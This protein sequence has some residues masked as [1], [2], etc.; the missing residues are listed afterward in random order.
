MGL[1]VD[2]SKVERK[3]RLANGEKLVK[4][5]PLNNIRSLSSNIFVDYLQTILMKEVDAYHKI[6]TEL[7]TEK[8]AKN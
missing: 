1:T 3:R 7:A 8:R 5:V 4:L 6:K 2:F